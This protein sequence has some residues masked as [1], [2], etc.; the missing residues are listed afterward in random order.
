MR[1]GKI[2]AVGTAIVVG[3]VGLSGPSAA[4]ETDVTITMNVKDCEGCV[5]T[6][7]DTV[8]YDGGRL[9]TRKATV[10]GGVATF[11][12]P[13]ERTVGMSFDVTHKPSADALGGGAVPVIAMGFKGIPSGTSVSKAQT[14]AKGARASWC[15]AGAAPGAVSMTINTYYVTLKN[16]PAWSGPLW[17]YAWASPTQELYSK[18]GWHPAKAMG[19][20]DAPYC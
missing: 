18:P 12:V 16:P 9:F 10:K 4:A 8:G 14:R 1:A 2:A 7:Y 6:A 11:V 5:I 19:H 13:A 3:F 17:M 20:Q 15:W